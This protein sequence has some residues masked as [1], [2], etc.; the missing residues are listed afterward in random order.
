[1]SNKK[2]LLKIRLKSGTP[3]H[4]KLNRGPTVFTDA[5][6]KAMDPEEQLAKHRELNDNSVLNEKKRKESKEHSDF[7]S[8]LKRIR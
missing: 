2:P 4:P 3:P 8:L 6:K 1:M 7:A 5:L